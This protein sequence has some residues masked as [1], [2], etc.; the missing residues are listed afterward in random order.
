M[1]DRLFRSIYQRYLIEPILSRPFIR[2]MAP[3]YLT[4]AGLLFGLMWLPLLAFGHSWM[5]VSCLMI[6]GYLD[7]LDGAI[8]RYMDRRSDLGAALDISCDRLVELAVILGLFMA[9]PHA[10]A[11]PSLLML[12]SVLICVTTFLVVGIF[13]QNGSDK[14]FHYSPGLMERAEAFTLWI[15][16]ALWPQHFELCAYTFT[17]LVLSTALI[18]LLQFYNQHSAMHT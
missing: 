16:M 13:S 2:T 9:D 15:F 8:A 11:L 4:L 5:A 6:S 3:N 1:L 18:R 12:G 17:L 10:R 7:T 14:S